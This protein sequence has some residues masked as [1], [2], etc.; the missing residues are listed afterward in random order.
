MLFGRIPGAFRFNQALWK[1]QRSNLGFNERILSRDQPHDTS[2]PNASIQL[3]ELQ[4]I[5]NTLH[6]I[7]QDA[8]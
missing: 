1:A 4:Q 8:Q 3:N 5:Q 2:I 6:H 7:V